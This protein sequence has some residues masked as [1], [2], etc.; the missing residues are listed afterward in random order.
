MLMFNRRAP[1]T[2]II[3]LGGGGGGDWVYLVCTPWSFYSVL[4]VNILNFDIFLGFIITKENSV[5]IFR[6]GGSNKLCCFYVMH[7]QGYN[8]GKIR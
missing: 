5:D 4:R 2:T 6:G 7:I 1:G 3:G 8:L